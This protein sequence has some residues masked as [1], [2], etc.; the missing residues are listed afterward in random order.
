MGFAS[1]KRDLQNGPKR[2]LTV[3]WGLDSG[4]LRAC[5]EALD[6]G[7]LAEVLVTGPADKIEAVATDAG[8]NLQGFFIHAASTPEEGAAAAVR[9]IREGKSDLLMKGHLNTS[10]ILRAVLNKEWG[11]RAQALLSHIAAIELPTGRLALLTDAAM[12]VKP[13]LI[14]KSQIL[15]NA[16]RFA[17]SIGLTNPKV[18]VLASVETVN[19]QMQDTIDAACLT[20][21]GKRG[22]FSHKAVVDGPLAFDNAYSKEAAMQKGI[23]SDVAGEADIFMVQELTAGNLL[24]KALSYVGGLSIAGVIYGATCP[25][26]LTSRADSSE[27]K[28]NAIALACKA[29]QAK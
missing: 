24:Y 11:I 25:I 26:V 28:L 22:Q 6:Q 7:L 21:M 14:Q 20:L 19:P 2:S 18:A 12:N 3:A 27:S 4:V 16:I 8:L 10:V 29:L 1:L 5:R 17:W 9:L 23:E 15:D 13:D